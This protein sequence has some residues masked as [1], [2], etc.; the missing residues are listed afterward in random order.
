M[1]SC[2]T[3]KINQRRSKAHQSLFKKEEKMKVLGLIGGMS[4]ESTITYYQVINETVKR[5]LGGLHSAKCILYSVD[6]DEIER[7]QA[8]GEWAKSGEVLADAAKALERAGADLIVI[9]TNTMHKVAPDIAKAIDIPILHIA[10][11][12][13]LELKKADIH[14]VGI[15]GTKYTMTQD[16]YK[17]VLIAKGIDVLV[18]DQEDI[19]V[20]NDVI[21]N[22]L[23][24]GIIKDISKEKY[25]KI[26]DK[27]VQK[28]AEGIILGCTEIGLLI[29]Q[30]D[31]DIPL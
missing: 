31:T 15:L 6:F 8:S 23:C 3:I 16:F 12:T 29:K 26:I 24:L 5:E 25:L 2:I 10:D 21:Y 30:G 28:V 19:E 11:M 18:P 7:Y 17:N 4:F 1:I 13:A 9:C 27:L 22:E 20:V 14:R